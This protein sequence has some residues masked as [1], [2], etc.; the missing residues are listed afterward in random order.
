MST[1]TKAVLAD[2]LKRPYTR[3]LLP[4]S[5]GTWFARIVELPG[6]MTEG[7]SRA[8]ALDNLEDAMTAWLST[9]IEDGEAIPEPANAASYSG[10]F[11]VRV[12]KSLH[13]DLARRANAEGVSLNAL[14]TTSL[15]AV[16][17]RPV[18]DVRSTTHVP[19]S[20]GTRRRAASMAA[21]IRRG[22]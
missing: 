4:N 2:Y 18:G 8:E 15:A 21:R 20:A 3:E 6:C 16:A 12:P 5:D 22:R 13:R 11:M 14:V 1:A 7:S 10:K 9:A 19:P 17:G